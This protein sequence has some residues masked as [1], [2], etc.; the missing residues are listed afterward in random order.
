MRIAILD[1]A[2]VYGRVSR[3]GLQFHLSLSL[4]LF[5]HPRS[6]R[7]SCLLNTPFSTPL[8]WIY[9][10]N[11]HQTNTVVQKEM[12]PFLGVHWFRNSENE[13]I[14]SFPPGSCDWTRRHRIAK[15]SSRAV[16]ETVHIKTKPGV[17]IPTTWTAW[18]EEISREPVAGSQGHTAIA[19]KPSAYRVLKR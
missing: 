6:I 11:G 2:C 5:L 15:F 7:W 19:R 1:C 16:P 9:P 12:H 13:S 18:Q 8:P 10:R 14:R 17:S 4:S 3:Q